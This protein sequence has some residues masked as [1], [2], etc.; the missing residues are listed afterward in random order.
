MGEFGLRVEGTEVEGTPFMRSR[1]T[2]RRFFPISGSVG[3]VYDPI[4]TLNFGLVGS[5]TQRAPAE[6]ELFARGPHEATG[7][8]EVGDQ[9]FDEETSYTGELRVNFANDRARVEASAFFTYYDDYIFGELQGIMVDEDGDPMGM[10]ADLDLLFFRSRN[11]WFAGGELFGSVDLCEFMDGT[12][13]LDGQFDYVRARF[14][15]G[16]DKDVPRITPIR[17]GIGG[18]YQSDWVQAH[19]GFVRTERQND[20]SEF[21]NKTDDFTFLNLSIIFSTQQLF[22]RV[23]V[24]FGFHATN[25]L[26]QRARNVVSFNADELLLPGFNARGTVRVRF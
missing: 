16:D 15:S 18:F 9:D 10:D 26:N 24:E 7:T 13:G 8:F 1:K 5:V 25:M 21:E 23:P 4:E 17:W 22:A 3:L 19:F 20:V 11:A 14:T 2:D 12:F 6:V